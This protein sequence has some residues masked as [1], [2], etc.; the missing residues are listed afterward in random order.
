[1]ARRL[2]GP[3]MALSFSFIRRWRFHFGLRTLLTAIALIAIVMAWIAKER[4]QSYHEQQVAKQLEDQGFTFVRLGGPYEK[5]RAMGQSRGRWSE[6]ARHV[7]GERIVAVQG[8]PP[9]FNDLTAFE[10]LTNVSLL[11]LNDTQV[12]D[13]TPIAGFKNL[14]W[15]GLRNTPVTKDQLDLLRKSVPNCEMGFAP[16]P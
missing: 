11:N 5:P 1:M 6:L 7:L 14:Q 12:S 9:D 16:F 10:G 13:L 8:A 2:S 4:T 15:L 3:N